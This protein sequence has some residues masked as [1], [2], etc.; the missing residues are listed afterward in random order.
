MFLREHIFHLLYPEVGF[1]C[2]IV[3]YILALQAIEKTNSKEA[4][5]VGIPTS[6][7]LKFVVFHILPSTCYFQF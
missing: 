5:L 3:L 2:Y 7:I 1:L 6:K 4:I